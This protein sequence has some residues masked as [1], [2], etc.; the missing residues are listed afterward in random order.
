[1][2]LIITDH[3]SP[4]RHS[5]INIL[6]FFRIWSF[7]EVIKNKIINTTSKKKT[8]TKNNDGAHNFIRPIIVLLS[9][10]DIY[11]IRTIIT[12]INNIDEFPE[13]VAIHWSHIIAHL[14]I[15]RVVIIPLGLDMN[16]MLGEI[17]FQNQLIIIICRN[18]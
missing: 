13:H 10:S 8:H 16:R 4:P 18:T 3:P 17:R 5:N 9:D 1:M 14:E 15:P 2:P 6:I 7:R 11:Y 12:L